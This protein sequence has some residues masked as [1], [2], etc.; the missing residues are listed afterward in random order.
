LHTRWDRPLAGAVPVLLR[1]VRTYIEELG[2][3]QPSVLDFINETREEMYRHAAAAEKDLAPFEKELAW[4]RKELSR[5]PPPPGKIGEGYRRQLKEKGIEALRRLQ[6]WRQ[7][8]GTSA[9]GFVPRARAVVE[10][11]G[12]Q[13]MIVEDAV[14]A[15]DEFRSCGDIPRAGDEIPDVEELRNDA[16]A[17]LY[18]SLEYMDAAN[19]L[20]DALRIEFKRTLELGKRLSLINDDPD[21]GLPDDGWDDP[22]GLQEIESAP[23]AS[24][25]EEIDAA[26]AD[27][28]Q[29]DALN[30]AVA[31]ERLL[32]DFENVTSRR[33]AAAQ[34]AQ[35]APPKKQK[36]APIKVKLLLRGASL[37]MVKGLDDTKVQQ[38]FTSAIADTCGVAFDRVKVLGFQVPQQDPD[39]IK[40]PKSEAAF[41]VLPEGKHEF[42]HRLSVKREYPSQIVSNLD[43]S[44]P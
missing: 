33:M 30:P 4:L 41:H 5:V 35:E 23:E 29:I 32:G 34:A 2:S 40:Q 27:A 3:F 37:E 8:L 7:L 9:P 31:T 16:A 1:A 26:D 10:E 25:S 21:T 11:K 20:A 15:A 13:E 19:P 18:G 22:V 14:M 36:A 38:E 43:I 6:R 24:P 12:F 17:R 28:P 44:S 42:H 39:A